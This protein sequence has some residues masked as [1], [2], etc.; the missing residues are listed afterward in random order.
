M[1]RTADYSAASL[2]PNT[3]Y[4]EID[5]KAVGATYA[6][7]VTTPPGYDAKGDKHYPAIFMPD[8]NLFAPLTIP[9]VSMLSS[10]EAIFPIVP[11]IQV[12]IGYCGKE[13]QQ[14]LT[15][16]M[17]DLLPP[18]EP[19]SVNNVAAIDS[20]VASGVWTAEFGA[21]YKAMLSQGRAD[22]FLS[23]VTKELYT[24]VIA[25]WRID[26]STTGLWGDSYGG[27]FSTWAALQ[28]PAEFTRIGAGSPGI[29][30]ADS[31]VFE[32]LQRELKSGADF[33]GRHLH[34]SVCSAE[35]TEPS[36]YQDLGE[37]YARFLRI[38][39]ATPL[40]GLRLTTHA[41]PYESH[42][43]GGPSNWFSFLRAC[44]SAR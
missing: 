4:F 17:R 9:F 11:Y 20:A 12:T 37:Q 18:G 43:T 34:L 16:R 41:V 29:V 39:G 6:V 10:I 38:L 21:A 36:F 13:A 25:R 15:I 8:G 7:W 35:I 30:V 5:S 33:S 19:P 32:L 3:E 23:F 40:K 2:L 22:A 24:E 27:L 42:M 44:Y 14:L 28:R 26:P 1:L 31:K